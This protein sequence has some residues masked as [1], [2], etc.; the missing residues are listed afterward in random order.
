[1]DQDSK[2]EFGD[3]TPVELI[4]GGEKSRLVAN[5]LPLQIRSDLKARPL[6]RSRYGSEWSA[7]GSRDKA[8]IL[9][10]RLPSSRPVKPVKFRET[11]SRGRFGYDPTFSITVISG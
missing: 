7:S 4:E 3:R 9:D 2:P 1:M 8:V 5:R 10:I 11:F 6:L